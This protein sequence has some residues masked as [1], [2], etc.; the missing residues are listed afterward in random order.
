M[1]SRFLAL[2]PPV[3][4]L[5][6]LWA[7]SIEAAPSPDPVTDPKFAPA[8]ERAQR[9]ADKVFR[10]IL[11]NGSQ[12]KRAPPTEAAEPAAPAAAPA[13]RRQAP[14][15]K[16]DE[17]RPAAQ[18]AKPPERL[19]AANDA[20]PLVRAAATAGSAPAGPSR[21]ASVPPAPAQAASRPAGASARAQGPANAAPAPAA[22]AASATA[23]PQGPGP[24]AV[25]AVVEPVED[26]PLILVH[27]V[28][29]E[30]P[31]AILRRQQKGSVLVRFEVQTD[32]SVLG[33]EVVKTSN[34]RLNAPALQAVSQWRF[35]PLQQ[36]QSGTAEL[37]YD[38][39]QM[40]NE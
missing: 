13:A 33:A 20:T 34:P 4:G 23:L 19:P 14:R 1:A 3:L 12:P 31:A 10:W 35:K 2:P 5:L 15:T 6:L 18:G 7:G 38:M 32:G 17:P 25:A 27:Q 16:P 8:A 40:H 36:P 37:A 22:A 9:E 39:Q 26:E 29:P 11:I 21:S 28:E 24:A 30:F